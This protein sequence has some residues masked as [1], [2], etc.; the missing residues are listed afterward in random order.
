MTH[1]KLNNLVSMRGLAAWLVVFFH[2]KKLLQSAYP[3]L[4]H[5]L[6][7][8]IDHGYLA[9]DFFFVLSGFIIFINYHAKFFINFRHNALI[10]YWNRISR[11]YPVHLFMLIAYLLLASA[12]LYLSSSKTMPPGYTAESF[13]QSLVLIQAWTGNSTSWNVPSWSI[14]AEWFVYLLFPF[15]AVLF[16]RRGRGLVAYFLVATSALV[17]LC[18]AYFFQGY[19]TLGT[20]LSSMALVRA[21]CEFLLG[22]VVGSLFIHHRMVLA[23]GR[24]LVV[25]MILALCL[26]IFYFNLPN[27]STVP[28]LCFLLVAFLS[29]DTSVVSKVLSNKLLVYLGEISYSTYIVHYFVYDVFKAGWV[30]ESGQVSLAYLMASFC[31]VLI[32][33]ALMHRMLEVPAQRYLRVGFFKNFGTRIEFRN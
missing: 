25:L 23:N 9:V 8:F 3:Q 18:G 20:A 16:G 30:S 19:E 33:S 21:L 27:F 15:V 32:L 7:D 24:G 12:F 4:S 11:V 13:L 22:T 17:L 29:V 1:N 5:T 31:V 6:Y 26:L 10:F 14:S 2:S 28:L